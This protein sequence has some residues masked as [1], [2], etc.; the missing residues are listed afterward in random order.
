MWSLD[1]FICDCRDA[2]TE[3]SDPGAIA[4]AMAQAMSETDALIRALGPP[5]GPGIVPLY[6]AR[7]LTILNVIWKPSMTVPPHDHQM[8]A[9]IGIYAGREDNIFWRRIKDDP[10][11]KI[12]ADGARSI[13][14]GEWT[15]LGS[16]IIHS[17]TN[18]LSRLT[19]AIHVYGGD[20]FAVERSEWDAEH[21]HETRLDIERV[22]A[23][24]SDS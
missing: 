22:K 6:R 7:D 11:G 17:V 5:E 24:F 3:G 2:V 18:P 13:G 20:F 19:G 14:R 21:L 10:N 23:M 8:W 9:A 15:P 4:D 12:E 16:D 1:R